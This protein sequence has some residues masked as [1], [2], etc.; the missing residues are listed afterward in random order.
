MKV[1]FT[2]GSGMLGTAMKRIM[3]DFSYPSHSEMDVSLYS[4]V[5]RF[6][7]SGEFDTVIHAAAFISPPKVAERP[8]VA[9]TTNIMGTA[10]IV[11]AC[12]I[13][14]GKIRIIY[15]STDYVFD[16]EKGKYRED[17]PVRP[18]SKYAWSK[19]GGECAV[20]CYDNSLIIRTSFGADQFPY[21]AA[22]HDQWT[23][24][25][26]VS[27]FASFL[28]MIVKNPEL[29]GVLHVGSRI[30]KT[31]WEFA[32]SISPGKEIERKSR[33]TVNW[34]VPRDVSLDTSRFWKF[35]DDQNGVK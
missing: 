27:E 11:D 16:G 35:V 23:N 33:T 3:P 15:I 14:G 20:K 34:F 30:S 25:V 32:S 7:E 22:Y 2:G 28:S 4:D 8:E 24:R 31:V 5:I 12:F 6:I 18:T 17:D 21:S 1:L 9:V 19:L 13:L 26:T 29:K 10:N